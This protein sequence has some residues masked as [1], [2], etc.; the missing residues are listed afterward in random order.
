MS[1]TKVGRTRAPRALTEAS[2]GELAPPSTDAQSTGVTLPSDGVARDLLNRSGPSPSWSKGDCCGP[3]PTP[4]YLLQ[5]G[6]LAA[7]CVARLPPLQLFA[8]LLVFHLDR[9]PL[10]AGMVPARFSRP[11]PT[12]SQCGRKGGSTP[13]SGQHVVRSPYGGLAHSRLLC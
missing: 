7:S 4:R 1:T 2:A 12:A 11:L 9:E 10:R 6:L 3:P 5:G 13:R 8:V